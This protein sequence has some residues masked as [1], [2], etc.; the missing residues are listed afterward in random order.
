MPVN[1]INPSLEQFAKDVEKHQMKVLADSGVSRSLLFAQPGNGN[2]YFYITTWP[3]HLCISGDMGTFVFSRLTDM[4]EFFRGDKEPNLGYWSEKLEAGTAEKYCEDT[5]RAEILRQANGA[6]LEP[7]DLE[8]AKRCIAR[9]ELDSE[10]GFYNEIMNWSEHE[11]GFSID[12]DGIGRCEEYTY[13]FIWCCRAI[14]WAIQQYD[15]A[16]TKQEAA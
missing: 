5:A 2:Q 8:Y 3:H 14:I 1:S 4:F 7:E 12:T 15:L 11:L 10:L 6:G 9:M 16:K 13:H